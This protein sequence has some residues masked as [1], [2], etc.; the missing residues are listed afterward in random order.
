MTNQPKFI[1]IENANGRVYFINIS[2][3]DEVIITSEYIEFVFQDDSQYFIDDDYPIAKA[4]WLE[5][6]KV[7]P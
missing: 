5:Y 7:S 6:W 4:A 2:K 3:V 1:R